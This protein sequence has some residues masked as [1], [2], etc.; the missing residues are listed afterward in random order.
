MLEK[1][2]RF[3]MKKPPMRMHLRPL[4]WL[5][6]APA[7]IKHRNKLT[8]TGMDG[9]RPPYLLLCNHNAFMDFK[10][11][12][13]ATFPHRVNYVVAIDGFIGREWLL[14]LI[15]C[16][17]KRKFTRDVTLV[18]QLKRVIENGDIAAVYPEARYS[19]C[20]TGAVLPDSLGQL[21][22]LLGV[23][24][25]TL[26]CHGHHVNSPFWNLPDHK[27]KG[28]EAEM[29]C[30]LTAEDVKTLS[31]A[32]MQKKIASY[33]VYD[34]FAWQ[35]EK[36]I[37]ISY[38]NR[39]KGLHKVLYQCPACGKEYR[40]GSEGATLFCGACGKRWRM[41]EFGQLSSESGETEFSH[42]PDWYEW[43][44]AN[45]RNEIAEGRYFFEGEAQ[46]DALPNAKKY[47]DIGKATLKHGEDGFTLKGVA[48]GE[49]YEISWPVSDLYSC[50][51]E[52]DYLGKKGDCVDLNTLTDTLYIYPE[53]E[54][55]SV[56][57]FALAT[58]ELYFHYWENKK[59]GK[60]A[61]RLENI[62]RSTARR[63][64]SPE[65][66]AAER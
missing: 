50:H 32:E 27:V 35:R 44:R 51:I 2:E 61:G 22:K 19:L 40:M 11:A 5:L 17:C 48:D 38:K 26:I 10:V 37:L 31:P 34:D 56:T 4:A 46:V 39:A 23:P 64:L 3:D 12:T 1:I 21:A 62:N 29:T 65:K 60:G 53:G 20:G 41:D 25:V 57:K 42:I 66:K 55:F 14:R 28:T 16:I 8:K 33:F 47:I 24:V 15:G 59:T 63:P 54:D 6:S 58:E 13:R 18:R 30:I 52:Y 45:V 9:I 7:L 36:G 43:E 49:P